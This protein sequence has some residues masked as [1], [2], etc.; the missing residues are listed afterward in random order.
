MSEEFEVRVN[1]SERALSELLYFDDLVLMSETI[2]RLRNKFLMWQEAVDS[3]GFNVDLGETNVMVCGS[4]TKDG[5]SKGKGVG[6]A[7]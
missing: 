6:S 2:D 7:A 1:L 4:I 5:M 3:K